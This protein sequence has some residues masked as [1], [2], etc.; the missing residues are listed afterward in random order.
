MTSSA[1]QPFRVRPAG[2]ADLPAVVDLLEQVAAE[3][4][5][6]GTE[7]VDRRQRL[8]DFT[9]SLSS[10]DNAIFVADSEGQV[11]GHVT[12]GLR[13]YGVVDLGMLVAEHWR[14]RGVG[15]A[16]LGTAIDWARNAGAH[17]V[18]LQLWTHNDAARALYRKFGFEDEGLLRRQYRRR[19]GELWDA[20]IM[21]LL[22]D[23]AGGGGPLPSRPAC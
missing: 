17:K 19:N 10:P 18:G 8:A 5:W 21:G 12:L 9:T 20:V 16:L 15:T 1:D 6:I 22:L 14:G 11:I 7:Q 13:S 3:G 4:R 23:G 2:V